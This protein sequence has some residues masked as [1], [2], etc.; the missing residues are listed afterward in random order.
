M[1]FYNILLV[2]AILGGLL[3]AGY[4][5]EQTNKD[6]SETQ[7]GLGMP[8]IRILSPAGG[9]TLS[10][11]VEIRWQTNDTSNP[12]KVD[13][14][15]TTDHKPFCPSCP[16]QEWHEIATGLEN[17]HVYQWGTSGYPPSEQYMIKVK[18]ITMGG[19]V[20]NTTANAFTIK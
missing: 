14:Y 15:Y 2:A 4:L 13:I 10:G 9:E 3:F 17:T 5:S 20:E 6:L 8:S 11:V 12:A 19:A 7:R 18:L 16:P 1:K